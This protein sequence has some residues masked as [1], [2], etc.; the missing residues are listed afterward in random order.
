MSNPIETATL[1][2][3]SEQIA[4]I[5]YHGVGPIVLYVHGW[6]HSGTLW[7][8]FSTPTNDTFTHVAVDLPG[9]GA[10]SADA[11][12]RPYLDGYAALI[13][14]LC[15]TLPE[16]FSQPLVAIVAHSL[17][18]LA[19]VVALTQPTNGMA[20]PKRVVLLDAPLRGI[21]LLKPLIL[22]YPLLLC[23]VSIL[24]MLPRTL[25][26]TLVRLA[27]WPTTRTWSVMTDAFVSDCLAARPSVL[28]NTLFAVTF[29]SFRTSDPRPAADELW[30]ARG[31]RD[32]F[33]TAESQRLFA[34][35]W[36]ARTATF[37]GATHTPHL[38]TRDAVHSWLGSILSNCAV[39]QGELHVGRRG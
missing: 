16:H 14:D 38:E 34:V 39:D 6:A 13:R 26:G 27:A 28:L 22:A 21:P 15:R 8:T 31:R 12:K 9:F 3:P 11:P 33:M 7:N 10:A 23:M 25:S 35:A 2:L 5:Y 4:R 19:T 30:L 17:G 37:E 32:W 1:R 18:S 24:R 36:G 20:G 29:A